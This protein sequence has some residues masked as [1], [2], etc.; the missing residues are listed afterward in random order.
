M[1]Q[2]VLQL[3]ERPWDPEHV[4]QCPECLETLDCF[5]ITCE[6]PLDPLEDEPDGGYKLCDS[7]EAE[8]QSA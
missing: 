1:R 2:F 8:R 5:D 3:E 6:V 7:C 4:H